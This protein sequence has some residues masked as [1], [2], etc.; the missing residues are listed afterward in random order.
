MKSLWPVTARQGLWILLENSL[1]YIHTGAAAYPQPTYTKQPVK[2]EPK[3]SL[4][5]ITESVYANFVFW[6]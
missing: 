6:L 2:G 1:I 4:D 3:K 5:V